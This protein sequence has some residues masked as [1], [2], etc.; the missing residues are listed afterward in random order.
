MSDVA[1]YLQRCQARTE[2]ALTDALVGANSVY[3][4]QRGITLSE[5]LREAMAYSTLA[6]GKRIRPALV[7]ASAAAVSASASEPD[8]DRIAA[9]LECMHCYSLVHDD[10]PAMD[11]DDLRR[12]R[13]TCHRQY[14]E[15]TAI[16]V[17]DAL[18]CLAFE[19]LCELPS[20]PPQ[21]GLALV[22]TLA[23]AA[24]GH[25]MVAG[26]Y[27]DLMAE[28]RLVALEELEALHRLKT[29]A[30]IR[31]AVRMGGLA[32][33]A[34]TAQLRAL[35]QFAGAIGLAFQVKDDL[36]DVEGDTCEL[37]KTR[38]ADQARNK[39]TYP[40]LLGLAA[41][42]EYC[43]SLY[44]Q[45]RQALAPLGANAERLREIAGIIVSRRS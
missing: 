6:G 3:S 4:S 20:V 9:A 11:D 44:R 32:A 31:A 7:F 13:P 10:L 2:R 25:G 16:L 21:Q 8:L 28:N 39:A 17:G 27:I 40:A 14:D 38:G 30:L 34:D 36:L 35:D 23:R 5:R 37:G 15:A 43:E 19:L 12:G 45:A 41:A 42:R 1:E 22:A 18:Q 33:A 24:G 29:G 26:Q